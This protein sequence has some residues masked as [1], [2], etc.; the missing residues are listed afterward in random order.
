MPPAPRPVRDDH[1]RL[2]A[3]VMTMKENLKTYI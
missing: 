2:I 3:S 1:D